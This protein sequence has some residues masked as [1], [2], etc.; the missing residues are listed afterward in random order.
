MKDAGVY[1]CAVACF[2]FNAVYDTDDAF[3]YIVACESN[4]FESFGLV[5]ALAGA[6]MGVVA[7]TVFAL[8]Y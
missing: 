4:S 3:G 2:A 7:E 5:N 6:A 1:F 8:D